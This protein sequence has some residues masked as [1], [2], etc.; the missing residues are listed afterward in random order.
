MLTITNKQRGPRGV[1]GAAGPILV[2][3]GQTVEVEVYQR[4]REHLEASGWFEIRGSYKANPDALLV[5]EPIKAGQEEINRAVAEA[6]AE[7]EKALVDKDAE[8]EAL[9]RQLA[10][11]QKGSGVPAL[12][13][14]HHG[15]GKFNVTEG[16]T[17][18]L[19][20]LSKADADAFNAMT[21]DE[22]RA[23]VDKAKV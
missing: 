15:G 7:A 12:K 14:E 16:E 1:N 18:H 9:K 13:A 10:D 19:K 11:A 5:G 3:P 17:V 22:K 2:D 6:K 20:G 4:E 8:I 23:Y 21:D